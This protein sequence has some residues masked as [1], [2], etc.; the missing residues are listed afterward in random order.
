LPSGSMWQRSACTIV[1]LNRIG[2]RNWERWRI[3][4]RLK[5]FCLVFNRN[6]CIDSNLSGLTF[7]GRSQY[8]SQSI[9]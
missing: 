9:Y 5:P 1:L 7:Q 4:H 6:R 3:S 2:C 8:Y